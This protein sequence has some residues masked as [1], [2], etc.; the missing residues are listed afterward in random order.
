VTDERPPHAAPDAPPAGGSLLRLAAGFYAIVTIFAFGYALFGRLRSHGPEG[1]FLGLALPSLGH[2]LAG[3]G[4]GL[5]LVALTHVARRA[6]PQVQRAVDELVSL[7][8]PLRRRDAVALALLS[9]VG[10]ELLFRGALWPHLGWIG[11]TFLF[12]I[13]HVIPRRR[14]WVYPIFAAVA[15]LL[16]GLLRET[17]GSVLPSMI[18]HATVNGINLA[19][20]GRRAARPAPPAAPPAADA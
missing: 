12:A 3:L 17:S 13:V 20:I 7:L 2:V 16:L 6:F 8:G 5:A 9:A 1:P 4:I 11:T 14:L 18:A 19:W 15:G 10:E